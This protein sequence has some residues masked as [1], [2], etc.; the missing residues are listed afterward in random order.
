MREPGAGDSGSNWRVP[1][2]A[3]LGACR[4]LGLMEMP[5][6]DGA[7]RILRPAAHVLSPHSCWLRGAHEEDPVLPRLQ[8]YAFSDQVGLW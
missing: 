7:C 5:F 2:R 4:I 6:P 8:P 1:L 3:W